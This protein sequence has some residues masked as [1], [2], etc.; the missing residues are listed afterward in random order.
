MVRADQCRRGVENKL[1]PG[2][3][4][5]AWQ[6]RKVEQLNLQAVDKL[7][8]RHSISLLSEMGVYWAAYIGG[9]VSRGNIACRC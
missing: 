9:I 5:L 6:R 3:C 2:W 1:W 7:I 8:P 4:S